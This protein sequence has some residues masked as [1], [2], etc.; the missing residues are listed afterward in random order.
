[1]R[2]ILSFI[3]EATSQSE[4]IVSLRLWNLTQDNTTNIERKRNRELL[5]I[6]EN[7]FDLDYQ[8]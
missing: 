6:I 7:E 8:N 5:E 3:K 1:M 4:M 2:S